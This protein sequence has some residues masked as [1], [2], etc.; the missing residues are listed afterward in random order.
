VPQAGSGALINHSCL[1]KVNHVYSLDAHS[2]LEIGQRRVSSASFVEPVE[3]R[4][5]AEGIWN[6]PKHAFAV[7]G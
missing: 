4:R 2:R 3:P 7:V 5:I 1:P 6:S